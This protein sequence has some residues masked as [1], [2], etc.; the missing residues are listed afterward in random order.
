MLS[1]STLHDLA[2]YDTPT[3]CN[4]IELFDVRPRNLGY[5]NDS[6][7]ACFPNLPPMVGFALTSTFRSLAPPKAGGSYGG[8]VE[9]IE[10]FA[11]LPGPPVIVFQDL[12]EPTASAT[13][14]EVMCTM[15]KSFGSA[16]L[17]TSGA[18]RDLDQVRALNFPAF[19]NGTICSHG[20][21]HIPQLNVPVTVGGIIIEPGML[22]HGDLNG[23][24]TIPIEIASEIPDACKELMDAEQVVLDYCKGTNLTPAGF[25]EARKECAAMIAR[26]TKRITRK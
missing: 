25:A 21:C 6:I 17:I 10:A 12:D 5:M 18:G 8:L 13:F 16:G 26:L 14:G 22:L 9:Q 11:D 4:V 19:T 2:K 7:K 1:A 3:V 23:V 24:T 15:Y 20:Y